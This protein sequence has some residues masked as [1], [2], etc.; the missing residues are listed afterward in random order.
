MENQQAKSFWHYFKRRRMAVGGLVMIVIMFLIAGLASF[1]APYDPGKTDVSVKL[2]PPSLQHNVGTDQLGRD[3]F[4]RMLYG[5]RISLSVG[6]VAVG[7]SIFIGILIGAV[8]GFYGGW[9]DSLL[10]RFVDTMLCFP[11]FFL[12]LTVVALLGPSIFNI[13]VVIGITSWMGT[14]RLV[15]AEFLSLRERD[16]TQAA[17]ALGVKDPRIIFR[18]ILP[19]ALAP[20]F[21]SAT[22]KVASAILVEAGL[23]FLGFGVQPPVPSWGNILTEGR[24]YIFDAWWLTVFPGLAILITV[25]SFNLLGEGLRDALDPRLRGRR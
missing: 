23:S 18:H 5:S 19:N 8:A 24:T 17:K 16:F 3:V 11:S 2:K 1:L 15:R 14:A 10:M 20:V 12:I 6:F 21:V 4:S 22:L 25:L 9:V 13:M 7:I